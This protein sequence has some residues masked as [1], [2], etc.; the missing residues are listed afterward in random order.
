VI[1][2]MIAYWDEWG[3]ALSTVLGPLGL[4]ISLIQSFRKHWDAIEEVFSGGGVLAGLNAIGTVINDAIL[5]PLQQVL[6]LMSN[7]P[8]IG[9]MA[10]SA[11]SF[12]HDARREAFVSAFGEDRTEETAPVVDTRA[13]EQD[14]MMESMQQTNNARLD[15]YV[16]DPNNRATAKTDADFVKIKLS[17]TH[18][19]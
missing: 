1:I 19:E 17:S 3:A 16:N 5:Y 14:A 11:A 15:L 12:V 10:G 4:V 6:E 2:A 7:L 9:D 13:A 18:G 8:L